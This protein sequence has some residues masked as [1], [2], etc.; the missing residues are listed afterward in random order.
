[1]LYDPET[2]EEDYKSEDFLM[3]MVKQDMI[4]GWVDTHGP[5]DCRKEIDRLWNLG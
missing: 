5:E 4:K 3:S 2:L 1:M